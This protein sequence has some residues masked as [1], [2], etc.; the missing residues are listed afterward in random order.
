MYN[1][2]IDLDKLID[3]LKVVQGWCEWEYPLMYNIAIDKV[4]E[5]IKQVKT[6][7]CK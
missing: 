1:D 2:C 6:N 7:E 4:I 3:D 5:L